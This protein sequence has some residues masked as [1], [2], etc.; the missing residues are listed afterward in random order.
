[1][2][3]GVVVQQLDV[4]G[5]QPPR[6]CQLRTSCQLIEQLNGILLILCQARH[7]GV[8]LAGE[9]VVGTVVGGQIPLVVVE[10]RQLKPPQAIAAIG[11]L[12]LAVEVPGPTPSQLT[13]QVGRPPHDFVV[14]RHG[15]GPA[16]LAALPG[17][18]QA[19]QPHDVGGVVVERL[20]SGGGI[21]PG[22]GQAGVVPDVLDVPDQMTLLVVGHSFAEPQTDNPVCDEGLPSAVPLHRH[23]LDHLEATAPDDLLPYGQQSRSQSG[24]MHTVPCHVLNLDSAMLHIRHSSIQFCNVSVRQVVRPCIRAVS[25]VCRH[26]RARPIHRLELPRDGTL[27]LLRLLHLLDGL[28]QCLQRHRDMLRPCKRKPWHVSEYLLWA[29]KACVGNP[30]HGKLQSCERSPRVGSVAS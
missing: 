11:N 20:C 19:Q 3:D 16:A 25:V 28:L 1:M 2:Q 6:H 14:H 5:L 13:S 4:S 26:P 15:A 18:L 9:I 29:R 21:Q 10:D 17:V 22:G 12:A 23:T 7:L 30:P 24:Q 8:S 27:H